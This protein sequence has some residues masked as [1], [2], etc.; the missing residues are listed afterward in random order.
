M[1]L[2]AVAGYI[3]LF[4][5]TS[6][7]TPYWILIS[8]IFFAPGAIGPYMLY[9]ACMADICDYDELHNGTRRE[10]LFTAVAGWF[11][12]LG[13]S[14]NMIG[15]GYLLKA[16]GFDVALGANQSPATLERLTLLAS[17][18]PAGAF[19][20]GALLM[21]FYPLSERRQRENRALLE[22]RRGR[23]RPFCLSLRGGRRSERARTPD[24]GSPAPLFVFNDASVAR[25]LTQSSLWFRPRCDEHQPHR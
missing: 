10:G 23:C 9:H 1:C 16:S 24:T 25:T 19:G 15:A 20:V 3:L 8:V 7:G 13:G 22:A 18:V 14:I 17:I 11:Y 2:V 12:K 21:V 5:L 4:F 6:A